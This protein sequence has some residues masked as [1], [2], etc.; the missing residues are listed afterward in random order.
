[1]TKRTFGFSAIGFIFL[2]TGCNYDRIITLSG[3]VYDA[4]TGMPIE[5]VSVSDGNYGMRNSAITDSN[6]NYS[7]ETYC[8]E[9]TIEI[10]ADGYTTKNQTLCTPFFPS[11][12]QMTL[13]IIL[14]HN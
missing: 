11:S 6:G 13:D 7:Y 2:F 14:E 3:T 8:E 4:E 10:T 12:Q 5:N 9:H 1:M